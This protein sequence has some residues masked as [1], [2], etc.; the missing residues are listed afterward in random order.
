[1]P[2]RSSNADVA[3]PAT[4]ISSACDLGALRHHAQQRPAERVPGSGEHLGQARGARSLEDR[5]D[6][7][8][9]QQQAEQHRDRYPGHGHHRDHGTADDLARDEHL[10]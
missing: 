9:H 1:V 2:N 4:E 7:A 5:R 8:E 3:K 6:G 10:P